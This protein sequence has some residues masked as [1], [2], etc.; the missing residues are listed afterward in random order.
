MNKY[1]GIGLLGLSLLLAGCGGSAPDTTKPTVT[2]VPVTTPVTTAGNVTITATA[3]DNVAI[4]QVDFYDNGTLVKSV[5]A[6]PYT[7]TV[8]YSAADNGTTHTIKAVAVDTSGQSAESSQPITISIPVAPDTTK[9]TVTLAPITTP[10]TT[11]GNVTITATATDNVAIRQVDFY[12]NGTLVKSVTAAP[13]TTTVTYS[14]ADNGTTHTIKAVAVDTSGQSAE[15][16]QPI[17]ISIP[18]VPADT[19]K[20]TVTLD[21]NPM[22]INSNAWTSVTVSGMATDDIGIKVVTLA[23]DVNGQVFNLGNITPDSKGL[24]SYTITPATLGTQASLLNLI[25]SLTV[26]AQATDTSGNT[27]AVVSKILTITH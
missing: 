17:T 8:T 1:F 3:T 4:R 15:S 12:D 23:L 14:A 13:Y 16:S 18:V 19:T 21:I 11:A 9:P 26:T 7:T 20:P 5:T 6:A 25:S 22:T 2:L 10:V 27:S 24:Y